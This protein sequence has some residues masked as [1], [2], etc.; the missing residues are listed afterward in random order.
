MTRF[1]FCAIDAAAEN[2][3]TAVKYARRFL[4]NHRLA[5]REQE[6]TKVQIVLPHL[7]GVAAK[8]RGQKPR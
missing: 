5:L 3:F 6:G 2:L 8:A 4:G 7:G 1:I